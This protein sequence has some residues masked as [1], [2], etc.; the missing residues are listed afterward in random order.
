MLPAGDAA[1]LTSSDA[2]LNESATAVD[3]SEDT[4]YTSGTRAIQEGRWAEAA[5]IFIKVTA[6]HGEHAEGALYWRAYAENKQGKSAQALSTCSELRSTYPKSR[7]LDDCAALAIE[8]QSSG[9]TT[10]PA[11]GESE[12]LRLL[13]LNSQMRRD[14]GHALPELFKILTGSDAESYKEQALFVI[15][16]GQSKAARK[17]LSEM[18]HPPAN[19]PQSIVSNLPLQLRAQQLMAAANAKSTAL[20][21]TVNRRIGLDII[22]TGPDGKPVTGLTAADFT[23]EDNGQPQKAAMFFAVNPAGSNAPGKIDAGLA[24]EAMLMIDTVNDPFSDVAYARNEVS[25]FLRQNGG[26]LAQPTS[27]YFFTGNG[28]EH[29]AGPSRDGN[30]LAKAVDDAEGRLHPVRRSQGFYGEGERVQMSLSA[31]VDLT[32]QKSTAP[33][34]KIL[35]W[36]SRGWPLLIESDSEFF[37][38]PSK[39]AFH[40][41]T[42]LSSALRDARVTLDCID[43]TR[44]AGEE[45]IEWDRYK[46]YRKPVTNPYATRYGNLSLPI[47]AEQSGGV[48]VGQGI[49]F[50]SEEIANVLGNPNYYYL[51]FDSLPGKKKD[52]YHALKITVNRP[53]AKVRTRS[54]Y[55]AQP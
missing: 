35:I 45:A 25:K 53:G 9:S 37:T 19:A 23:I 44:E 6:R 13:A 42:V 47:L 16:Q 7:W 1:S 2:V 15:A 21:Q 50:L 5:E 51:S 55:Y 36:I 38:F 33:G 18:A 10:A 32:A 24:T 28:A 48:A 27:I 54:G 4:L 3:S 26:Q 34:R 22:V 14:E 49:N 12:H 52:E 11:P 43:P 46:T 31:L 39:V 20:P 41:V 17:M 40:F 30:L 8:I 29:M